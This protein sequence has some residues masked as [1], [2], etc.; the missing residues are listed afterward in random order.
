MGHLVDFALLLL[1]K[2]FSRHNT[3]K[4]TFKHLKNILKWW[5][6]MIFALHRASITL[7]FI[8]RLRATVSPNPFLASLW[9]WSPAVLSHMRSN[10]TE[11]QTWQARR[12]ERRFSFA[13]R[14]LLHSNSASY[15]PSPPPP[16]QICAAIP[17]P[18]V[19]SVSAIQRRG[20][21][22]EKRH[23]KNPLFSG[24]GLS[25]AIC[26]G[27]TPH[28]LLYLTIL[29]TEDIK[30]LQTGENMAAGVYSNTEY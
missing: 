21:I 16:P 13:H 7:L 5:F 9:R 28:Q 14:L 4:S 2:N 10:D 19:T 25:C 30:S 23:Q 18:I 3:Y 29:C 17:D 24:L 20:R 1:S 26:F 11:T 22:S 12:L 15:Y 6:Q 8:A 27:I